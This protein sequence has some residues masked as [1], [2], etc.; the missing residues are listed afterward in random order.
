MRWIVGV[1]PLG[2]R[3]VRFAVPG[4]FSVW[5]R[6]TATANCN[7]ES[8]NNVAISVVKQNVRNSV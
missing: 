5:L 6:P 3:R 2:R 1:G 7:E 8:V 4:V